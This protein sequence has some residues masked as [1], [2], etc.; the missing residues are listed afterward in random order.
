[1]GENRKSNVVVNLILLPEEKKYVVTF[2]KSYSYSVWFNRA[3][4]PPKTHTLYKP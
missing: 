4:F 3:T 2:L 1:M